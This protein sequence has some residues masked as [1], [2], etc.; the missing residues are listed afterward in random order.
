MRLKV[1][2]LFTALSV[3][4]PPS[5]AASARPAECLEESSFNQQIGYLIVPPGPQNVPA[6]FWVDAQRREIFYTKID[7]SPDPNYKIPVMAYVLIGIDFQGREIFRWDSRDHSADIL[8]VI[9]PPTLL[10][11]HLPPTER[12]YELP[13]FSA[14]VPIPSPRVSKIPAFAPGNLIAWSTMVPGISVL[15][16]KGAIVWRA[17]VPDCEHVLW[18]HMLPNGNVLIHAML[19]FQKK[20]VLIYDPAT[21]KI[22]KMCHNH[23]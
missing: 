13:G 14:A 6:P 20:D 19:A 21:Q 22:V 1:L 5:F 15:N 10:P 7:R 16:R 4:A 2:T 12:L 8:S 23:I 11:R 3:L 18:A 17:P 9:N